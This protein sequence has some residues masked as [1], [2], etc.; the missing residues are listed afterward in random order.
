MNF[1][2]HSNIELLK[3]KLYNY[4]VDYD[5][6]KRKQISF[7]TILANIGALFSTI[8]G[9][10]VSVFKFYSIS[11]DNHKMLKTILLKKLKKD[12]SHDDNDNNDNDNNNKKNNKN[13]NYQ[14]MPIND[15][16]D[17]ND[18]SI[19][20]KDDNLL[21]TNLISNEND[22]INDNEIIYLKKISFINYLLNNFYCKKLDF[23][24]QERIETCNEIV[25]TYMSYENILYNMMVLEN[26]L[27][28][29]IWNN[30]KLK[31]LN[32]NQLIGRLKN[33]EKASN[34]GENMDIEKIR[35]SI[36]PKK[37]KRWSIIIPIIFLII[38]ILIIVIIALKNLGDQCIIGDG[39]KCLT[40]KGKDCGSCNEG[41]KLEEG[42]CIEEC[43]KGE[44]DKCLTCNG[45]KCGSCNKGYILVSGYC[46]R[47]YNMSYLHYFNLFRELT[48]KWKYYN[49]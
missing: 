43:I 20:K 7:L 48:D 12:S 25:K 17:D 6:Y 33:L 41:Y 24:V 35:D 36:K 21:I 13:K 37:A 32:N 49:K 47:Y 2:Y 28:D 3:I 16:N 14:L 44:E 4:H 18:N 11:F 23:N 40:C 10:L 39:D 5:Q 1:H 26:L 9:I 42:K 8:K 30:P 45:T 15:I 29:Y 46:F 31:Y 22:E 27:S 34:N 19:N 38:I